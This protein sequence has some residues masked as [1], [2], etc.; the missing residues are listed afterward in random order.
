[1]DASGTLLY[2]VRTG[3]WAG[4][5]I[6]SMEVPGRL[7]PPLVA[8]AEPAGRLSASAAAHLGL[9]RVPVAAGA[10]DTAAAALGSGLLDPGAAQLTVG[11]GAQVV[12]PL[13]RPAIDP[14]RATRTY[15]AAAPGRWY[16]LAAV[17]S[18]GL[19]LEWALRVLGAGWDD[20]YA[21]LDA[22]PPGAGGV[23][24]LP[25]L[26]DPALDGAWL[27]LR[28][29]HGRAHL[30]RAALEGVAFAIREALEALAGA[31]HRTDPLRLAGGGSARPA[32]RQLL[33]DVLAT[34][35]APQSTPA[36]SARGAALL[37]GIT[38]GAFADAGATLAIAQPPGPAVEPLAPE[39][40]E[41]P[42]RRYRRI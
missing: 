41:E 19:A 11:S 7:L 9:P 23:T 25:H 3:G 29:H 38:A 4:A 21:A 30:L 16:A 26:T 37:A 27:G 12:V 22:V 42:Y 15:R 1:S 24:F 39:A 10:A 5:V 33:A 13:D 35:L 17:Q 28:L 34:P 6:E 36:V 2:D 31:G 14:S 40:Y 20:A 18:A 8:S 32:W